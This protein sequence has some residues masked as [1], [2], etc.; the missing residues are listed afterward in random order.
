MAHK[1]GEPRGGAGDL[2]LV[3][4]EFEEV[5]KADIDSQ[6]HLEP[7]ELVSV[8]K[9]VAAAIVQPETAAVGDLVLG[10]V[11]AQETGVPPGGAGALALV[12]LE[13][14]DVFK[15]LV[16]HHTHVFKNQKMRGRAERA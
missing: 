15:E 9:S 8:N 3:D 2:A 14:K 10:A 7:V 1:T 12:E 11:G 5:F 4:L 6:T 16:Q 13:T